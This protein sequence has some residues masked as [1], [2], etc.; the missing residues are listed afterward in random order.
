VD[1]D[2]NASAFIA[3]DDEEAVDLPYDSRFAGLDLIGVCAE[4]LHTG[5]S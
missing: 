4:V 3:A 5:G 2:F 1:W